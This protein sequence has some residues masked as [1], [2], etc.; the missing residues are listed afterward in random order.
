LSL[1]HL[2]EEL[3]E[4][5]SWLLAEEEVLL[6]EQQ[7]AAAGGAADG[8]AEG[9]AA[10]PSSILDSISATEINRM[11]VSLGCW[12]CPSNLLRLCSCSAGT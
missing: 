8:T 7:Q 11:K 6:M 10:S 12:H 4:R 5:A 9:L 1:C 2:Q 3:A